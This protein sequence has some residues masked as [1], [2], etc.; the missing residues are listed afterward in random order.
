MISDVPASVLAASK[1]ISLVRP[2]PWAVPIAS[3]LVA[4]IGLITLG[5]IFSPWQQTVVGTGVVSVYSA[6]DR[7]QNI[8]AQIPGRLD[9]WNVN[10]GEFV[11]QGQVLAKLVDLDNRFLDERQLTRLQAQKR[12][13]TAQLAA[14]QKRVASLEK[15]AS[16]QAQSQSAA[17][18]AASQRF[19]QA[20][21]RVRAA[22]QALISAQQTLKAARDV[23]RRAAEE[24]LRQARE[25]VEQAEQA[26]IERQQ[27]L[28]TAQLNYDRIKSL[29]ERPVPLR[30]RRDFELAELELTRAQTEVK[31]AE[32][33]VEIAKRDANVGSLEQTRAELEVVRAQ[34]EVERARAA[35]EV[36]RR[37]T[38]IG[39]LD[40]NRVT[41]DTS[42]T[43]TATEAS[44]Q[45][46]METVNNL[47]ASIYRLDVEL[48]NLR[49]RQ[50]Q[51][52]VRAPRDGQITRLLR[53]GPGE[54]VKAGDVLAVL[55]PQA[56][57]PMVELMISD[58][59][60]AFVQVGDPAR[61]QFAGFPAVQV[62]GFPEFMVGT[63]GGRVKAIDAVDDGTNRFRLIIE[64]EPE[65]IRKQRKDPPWPPLN[66]TE[67]R[68]ARPGTQ[69]AGWVMLRRVPLGYE[70]WRQFN[71]FPPTIERDSLGFDLSNGAKGEKN[72]GSEKLKADV[73]RKSKK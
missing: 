69:V 56:K 55:V 22:Q 15:Q 7:P 65:E 2:R 68:A 59:D 23:A 71:A 35:L 62:S 48:E 39:S 1:A 57:D 51:Q 52:I 6:M 63:F 46:A 14:A 5:L 30:S 64:P 34:T 27:N 36:A 40:I 17:V 54:T 3:I 11:K 45:A 73:K 18:P 67:P 31:R 24:R 49:R 13:L 58:N 42:A 60:V 25:R 47:T 32:N 28:V 12:A 16:L 29:Y 66:S 43:I 26:R 19:D 72:G 41:A 4:L 38:A 33:A 50:D 44:I 70:L 21:D 61:L 37:D 9:R 8:E 53:L 20:R 10:E